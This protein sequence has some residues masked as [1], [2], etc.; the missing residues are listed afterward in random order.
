[1]RRAF[2]LLLL[3]VLAFP[4]SASAD[5]SEVAEANLVR[6]AFFDGRVSILI[7]RDFR[8]MSAG[9]VHRKYPG[10]DRPKIVL[11]D[12]STEFDVGL[13][14]TRHPIT[15][16]DLPNY[17]ARLRDETRRRLPNARILR[18]DVSDIAGRRF[19]IFHMETQ[20]KDTRLDNYLLATDM[21]GSMLVIIFYTTVS[22]GAAWTGVR[23]R[24]IQSIR[25]RN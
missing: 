7:P 16:D 20:A 21:G 3:C 13:S 12:P 18:A 11:T 2:A 17:V 19:M 1:M 9:D 23:D 5:V 6:R 15:R 8:R 10:R 24:I 4:I 22:K 14:H 25:V